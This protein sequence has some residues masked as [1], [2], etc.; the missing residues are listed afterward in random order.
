MS[1]VTTEA[2]GYSFIEFQKK[3]LDNPSLTGTRKDWG[4]CRIVRAGIES[5][6]EYTNYVV[7]GILVEDCAN[8]KCDCRVAIYKAS[9]DDLNAID[10]VVN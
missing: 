3:L 1:T 5:D 6:I 2:K 4:D 8:K 7:E 10:W 9:S